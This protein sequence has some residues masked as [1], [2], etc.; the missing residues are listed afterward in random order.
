MS[1]KK[2]EDGLATEEGAVMEAA[3]VPVTLEG[4]VEQLMDEVNA[5]KEQVA[6]LVMEAEDMEVEV[7]EESEIDETKDPPL[8]CPNCGGRL[9]QFF[10]R[11]WLHESGFLSR[12]QDVVHCLGCNKVMNVEDLVVSKVGS[13]V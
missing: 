8:A 9:M 10:T 7:G 12:Q 1:R 5:L 13:L 11:G 6:A 4:K 3:E 2:N